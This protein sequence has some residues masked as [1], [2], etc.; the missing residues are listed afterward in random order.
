MNVFYTNADQSLTGWWRCWWWRGRS[1]WRQE[2]RK[3]GQSV[4]SV[5]N[6]SEHSSFGIFSSLICFR[7]FTWSYCHT[8]A[9][10]DFFVS[11]VLCERYLCWYV[12]SSYLERGCECYDNG[13]CAMSSH[14]K[15]DTA[16]C[17]DR[18]MILLV[19]FISG[20]PSWEKNYKSRAQWFND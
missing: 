11:F 8:F 6:M 2:V 4:R 7:Y 1:W 16:Y 17:R 9:I 15:C 12:I 14:W 18:S 3:L 13:M 5:I 20:P 10:S 19:A